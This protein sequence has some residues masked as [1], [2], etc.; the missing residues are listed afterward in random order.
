MS[1]NSNH[2]P[3]MKILKVDID[4]YRNILK[5][6]FY[7]DSKESNKNKVSPKGD[8][9]KRRRSVASINYPSDVNYILLVLRWRGV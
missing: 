6:L 9:N 3:P 8:Q 7:V 5:M 1:S 4:I 2:C